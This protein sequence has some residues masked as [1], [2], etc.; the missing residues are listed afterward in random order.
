[1]TRTGGGNPGTARMDLKQKGAEL[2]GTAGPSAQSQSPIANGK[3]TTL[4]GVTSVVFDAAQNNGPSIH[5]A[6][7][8]VEGH[9]KGKATGDQNGQKIEADV[10]VARAK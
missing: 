10:D 3:V 6:L 7:T 9:L 4:K 1:L 8:L 2:T 5:F